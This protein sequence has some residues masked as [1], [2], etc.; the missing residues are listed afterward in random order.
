MSFLEKIKEL[1][2]LVGTSPYL[3]W[4]EKKALENLKNTITN[5]L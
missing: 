1:E 3:T 2:L 5:A 4:E